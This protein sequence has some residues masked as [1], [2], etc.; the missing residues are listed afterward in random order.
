LGFTLHFKI[1]L[2]F[3]SDSLNLIYDGNTSHGSVRCLKN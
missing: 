1:R 3:D 2:Y